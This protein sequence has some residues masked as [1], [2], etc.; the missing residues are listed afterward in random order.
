[1]ATKAL[2]CNSIILGSQYPKCSDTETHC[3][4]LMVKPKLTSS[5]PVTAAALVKEMEFLCDDR[6]S[7]CVELVLNG[8]PCKSKN[9]KK[10]WMK[11]SGC[12]CV[13]TFLI[14]RCIILAKK[15]PLTIKLHFINKPRYV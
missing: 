15:C 1:M 5:F 3:I 4:L 11:K 2:E 9:E 6:F 7:P 13:V 8:S 14:K 10:N 12:G